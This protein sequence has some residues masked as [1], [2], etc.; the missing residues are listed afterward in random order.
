MRARTATQNTAP[1]VAD[2]RFFRVLGDPTRLAIIAEL[3]AGPRTVGELVERIGGPQSRISN[4]LACLRWCRFVEFERVGRQIRYSITDPR[5]RELLD[6]TR[7]L[8]AD[9]AEHLAS[10]DR[11]GP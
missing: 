6:I 8:V 10:C 3:L 7:E 4:H 11:I 9:T 5:L 2:A 1:H